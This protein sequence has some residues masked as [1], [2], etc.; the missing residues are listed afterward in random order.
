MFSDL[1]IIILRHRGAFVLP[2][3]PVA[4]LTLATQRMR[5]VVRILVSGKRPSPFYF[6]NYTALFS[7][8]HHRRLLDQCVD[9]VRH[10]L[11]E[12]VLIILKMVLN[13]ARSGTIVVSPTR[14]LPLLLAL[15]LRYLLGYLP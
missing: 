13:G 4:S 11:H 7:S 6:V 14:G 1:P 10:L 15:L 8:P 3:L 9:F 2:S 12:A 5:P